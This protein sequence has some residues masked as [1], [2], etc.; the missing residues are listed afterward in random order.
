MGRSVIDCGVLAHI[1]EYVLRLRGLT[2]MR[3]Q[4]VEEAIPAEVARWRQVWEEAR[5]DPDGWLISDDLVYHEVVA[6]IGEDETLFY[7]PVD[8]AL[9][10]SRRSFEGSAKLVRLFPDAADT[11]RS[12]A[13]TTGAR[14]EP[15]VWADVTP[16]NR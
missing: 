16:T 3:L 5:V 1:A 4:V 15:G 9:V 13:W 12:V 7:D 2:T 6:V 14:L 10:G 11:S 8:Q